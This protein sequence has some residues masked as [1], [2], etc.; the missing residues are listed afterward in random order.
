[1]MFN[2]IIGM[3]VMGIITGMVTCAYMI[4]LNHSLK[5][6]DKPKPKLTPEEVVKQDE[7]KKLNEGMNKVLNFDVTTARQHYTKG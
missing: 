3:I 1:M 4:G 7:L 6:F 5:D 2:F